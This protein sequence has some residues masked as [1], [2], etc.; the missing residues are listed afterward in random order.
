MQPLKIDHCVI[1]VSDWQRSNR[2]Y[3]TMLGAEVVPRQQGFA[4]KFGDFLLNC[5]GPGVSPRIVAQSPVVPGDSDLCF[6]WRGPIATALAHLAAHGV[7]V[8][9]GPVATQ[10]AKGAATS[11]YFRDPDG[12]LLEFMSYAP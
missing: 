9:L 11:V 10:G 1:H 5:H 4:Y 12:S 3:A 7:P 2:F 6:E 8:A